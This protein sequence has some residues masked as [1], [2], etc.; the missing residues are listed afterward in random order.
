[1]TSFY[2]NLLPIGIFIG[3]FNISVSYW[4]YKFN[5]TRRS[6]KPSPVGIELNKKIVKDFV[7]FSICI[8]TIGCLISDY[9]IF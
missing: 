7:T 1:M 3:I 9:F 5:L 4:V 2:S 6:K 8:F